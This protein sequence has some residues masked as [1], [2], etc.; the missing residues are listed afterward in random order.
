MEGIDI[1]RI[2][3]RRCDYFSVR[4]LFLRKIPTFTLRGKPFS[5]LI[6]MRSEIF[7][8]DVQYFSKIAL[9]TTILSLRELFRRIKTPSRISSSKIDAPALLNIRGM[10]PG[11][12]FWFFN[13]IFTQIVLYYT[14][15]FVFH[16]TLSES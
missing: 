8:E 11:E 13:C 5:V 9:S 16:L 14:T 6:F 10:H 1:C 15:L 7:S 4:L 3:G 12:K 2:I